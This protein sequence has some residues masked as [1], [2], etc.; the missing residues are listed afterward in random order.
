MLRA[1]IA[2][3]V[4][5]M[6]TAQS[7]RRGSTPGGPDNPMQTA[8]IDGRRLAFAQSGDGTPTVVLETGLGAESVE[9]QAVQSGIDD[10]NR[11]FRY[12][13]AARGASDRGPVPRGASQMIDD[14]HD[15]LRVTGVPGP[16]LLVG[17]SFGGLL[18]R[19]FA[20]RYRAL[21]CGLILVD[22]QHEDQ[23]GVF[24]PA[25][26]A[27]TAA[28][29][30]MLRQMRAFWNGGWRDPQSTA[31]RIDFAASFQSVRAIE[32]LGDLPMHIIT[33]GTWLN[34]QFIPPAQRPE[35]QLQWDR[36]QKQFLKLSSVATQSKVP[37]S[38]HFVQRDQ[39]QAVID[40][41]KA[42]TRSLGKAADPPS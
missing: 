34:T 31:E 12:D 32:S 37:S 29:S 41:I 16:Y 22:A 26:P 35:L 39:P 18:M 21:V 40:A 33:A 38:G 13:R 6:N 2:L 14:L 10:G 24:G 17:H 28:D 3:E 42:M 8:N 30:P 23:F 1:L 4:T 27:P 7:N 9:W 15:L 19:L 20:H 36:L 25:F 5:R 11:V